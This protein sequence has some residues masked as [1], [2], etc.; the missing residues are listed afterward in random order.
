MENKGPVLIL[1][2]DWFTSAD[3]EWKAQISW[4]KGYYRLHTFTLEGHNQV[5][6]P[7]LWK[8]SVMETNRK[9]LRDFLRHQNE[10]VFIVT[11]GISAV[12]AIQT[13]L[14]FPD[15]IRSM[16]LINPKIDFRGIRLYAWARWLPDFAL[17]IGL[18]MFDP[19]GEYGNPVGRVR[20]QLKN[21]PIRY[22]RLYMK[23][24]VK[25]RLNEDLEKVQVKTCLILGDLD[26]S[27]SL[28]SLLQM[29][30]SLPSSHLIRYSNLGHS[31]H[32][33]NPQ[34]INH[35]IHDFF[36]KGDG[37]VSRSIDGIKGFLKNL[38]K[39]EKR[40]IPRTEEVPPG[41]PA[42]EDTDK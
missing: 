38:F 18:W 19:H 11:H 25:L 36:K 8:N 42:P 37:L 33:E 9:Q 17:R 21:L 22:A 2:H 16:V 27:V 1:I 30:D 34:I 23:D 3:Q 6:S 15:R 4:L 35:I 13:A 26:R 10:P 39:K 7:R 40:G 20:Q 41:L 5:F 24:L 28:E 12:T 29:N 14:E 32:K 31:P